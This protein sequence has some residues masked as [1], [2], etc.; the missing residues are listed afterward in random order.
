MHQQQGPY[1]NTCVFNFIVGRIDSAVNMILNAET[2]T[3]SRTCIA[4]DSMGHI[5]VSHYAIKMNL[6]LQHRCHAWFAQ[7][8]STPI[9]L[10]NIISAAAWPTTT[11]WAKRGFSLKQSINSVIIFCGIFRNIEEYHTLIAQLL[12]RPC[13]I[14]QWWLKFLTHLPQDKLVGK[15]QAIT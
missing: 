4:Q 3:S 13:K 11:A 5:T 14:A 2:E 1:M 10:P 15:S 6:I 8:P 9:L 7:F 12:R